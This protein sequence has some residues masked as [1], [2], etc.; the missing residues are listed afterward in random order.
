MNKYTTF[1][2]VGFQM[3]ET[4]IYVHLAEMKTA[5]TCK[6][7]TGWIQSIQTETAF[8]EVMHARKHHRPG[9]PN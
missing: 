8:P 6:E 3:L 4:P 1:T 2:L 7:A 5:A 9:D